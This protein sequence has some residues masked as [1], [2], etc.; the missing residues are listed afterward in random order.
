[1]GQCNSV[2]SNDEFEIYKRKFEENELRCKI[3]NKRL[4]K[5]DNVND[6]ASI[7]AKYELSKK[8]PE[9]VNELQE[10][11]KLL[12]DTF[13]KQEALL[14]PKQKHYKQTIL[15]DFKVHLDKYQTNSEVVTYN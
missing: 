9:Y 15:K 5:K 10:S 3:L 2:K 4:N 8:L 12:C 14:N 1:M 6:V 11:Y 13:T 7:K